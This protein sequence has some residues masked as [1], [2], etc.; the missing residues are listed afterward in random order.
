MVN[1]FDKT[2]HRLVGYYEKQRIDGAYVGLGNTQTLSTLVGGRSTLI[3]WGSRASS[4][5]KS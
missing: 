1:R 2:T 3:T 5:L 4:A